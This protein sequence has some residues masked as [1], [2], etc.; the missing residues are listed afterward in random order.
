MGTFQSDD[1]GGAYGTV[2]RARDLSQNGQLVAL[3]KV[4]VPL[5]EDGL[6]T[7]TLREITLLKQLDRYEHPNIVRLLD[8][9]YGQ[10]V[11]KEQ[12][13]VLF[14][15]FEHIDQDL[16]SYM[17][18]VPPPG[19]PPAR[20]KEIMFQILCGVD[21]LHSHRIIHRDLKPQ[22]VLISSGGVVKLADF[23][24]AKAYDFEM[25][26]TSVVVTLW[27]RAPEVLLLQAYATPVD[28]WSC[29]CMFAEL[30]RLKP[31]FMGKSEANQL[32]QIFEVTGTLR[33]EDWPESSPLPWSSFTPRPPAN[34]A[35]YV[36]TCC[37]LGV[38]LMEKMLKLNPSERISA[39]NALSHA[40]FVS[41]GYKRPHLTPQVS[42]PPVTTMAS[43]GS[44]SREMEQ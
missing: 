12:R 36:P 41:E 14:L 31:M 25:R 15:V 42:N 38:D 4:A 19:M 43:Q 26:L 29:G 37:N 9:C 10:R 20:V 35:V 27:Y 34:I 7:S 2:Y 13:L 11:D 44:S 21:F 17:E 30:F 28:V 23:G 18:R 39:S 8:V 6:P 16:S 3:K 1:D 40:Y 5:K 33:Q 24:L 22:N 32:D